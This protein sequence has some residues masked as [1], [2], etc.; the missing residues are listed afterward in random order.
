MILCRIIFMVWMVLGLGIH[1]A[2]DGK[3][4]TGKYSFWVAFISC[5]LQTLLLWG[6][7]FFN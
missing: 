2:E 1:L 5:A 6:G 4:R 3:P 7:G